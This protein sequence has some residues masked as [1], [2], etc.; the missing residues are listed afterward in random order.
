MQI[1]E[2]CRLEHQEKDRVFL[3]EVFAG[4]VRP[5]GFRLGTDSAVLWKG[6]VQLGLESDYRLVVCLAGMMLLRKNSSFWSSAPYEL[7]G[8]WTPASGPL[9]PSFFSAR[10]VIASANG[11]ENKNKNDKDVALLFGVRLLCKQF[12]WRVILSDRVA[13]YVLMSAIKG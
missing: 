2:I 4:F 7:V 13:S 9:T 10:E 3:T 12:D 11:F 1:T 5:A 8:S 6:F